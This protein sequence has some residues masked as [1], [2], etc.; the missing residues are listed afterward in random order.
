MRFISGTG[1]NK[2]VSEAR[3]RRQI[4]R[5]QEKRKKGAGERQTRRNRE[6]ERQGV[7]RERGV[8]GDARDARW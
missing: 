3:L 1:L 7:C 6:E 4:E 5:E 2:R 8:P